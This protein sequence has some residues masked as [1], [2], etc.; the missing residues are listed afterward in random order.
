MLAVS[1]LPAESLLF[2]FALR[3]YYSITYAFLW[4]KY[5]VKGLQG[6]QGKDG[7]TFS[8]EV[9]LLVCSLSNISPWRKRWSAKK[10]D[11]S[12]DLWKASQRQVTEVS[13]DIQ[14]TNPQA[15][16]TATGHCEYRITTIDLMKHQEKS[17]PSA[18]LPRWPY[19]SWSLHRH[20]SLYLH[21]DG[22]VKVGLL[23]SALSY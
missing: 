11:T 9:R 1:S 3:H 5:A 22:N 16:I 7:V 8:Q 2:S 21:F 23:L 20:S 14:P 6:L 18:I 15:D 12:W 10:T 17:I 4:I 19:A 13:F